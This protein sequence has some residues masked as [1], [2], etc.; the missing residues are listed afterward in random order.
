MLASNAN[1]TRHNYITDSNNTSF[2]SNKSMCVLYCSCYPHLFGA[3][4]LLQPRSLHLHLLPVRRG[5]S[6]LGRCPRLG[7]ART[8]L[9]ASALRNASAIATWPS[10]VD[11]ASLGRPQPVVRFFLSSMFLGSKRRAH[12]QE[13]LS[14]GASRGGRRAFAGTASGSAWSTAVPLAGLMARQRFLPS[15]CGWAG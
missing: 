14:D 5:A 13:K 1:K 12:G 10:R 7:L 3:V 9:R 2:D 15:E 11:P 8:G 6:S 4:S